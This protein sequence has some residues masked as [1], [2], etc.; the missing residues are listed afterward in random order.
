[1]LSNI[2]GLLG[3]GPSSPALRRILN[4]ASHLGQWKPSIISPS[5][6]S[7]VQAYTN[8][9]L[10]HTLD[11]IATSATM[12]LCYSAIGSGGGR[13]T[14]LDLYPNR[15]A[16]SRP[17]IKAD[18]ILGYTALGRPVQLPGS[19]YRQT[20]AKDSQFAQGWREVVNIGS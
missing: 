6:G 20:S 17:D 11:C 1:M 5:T 12:S 10:A 7:D 9:Q 15:L 16:Q 3:A 8:N 2:C 14:G 19:Y 18:W 13:Y 4:F